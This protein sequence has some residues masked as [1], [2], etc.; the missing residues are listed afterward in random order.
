MTPL[1]GTLARRLLSESAESELSSDDSEEEESPRDFE[2]SLWNARALKIIS[3][4]MGCAQGT[5]RGPSRGD[6]RQFPRWPT[7]SY[8]HRVQALT[9]DHMNTLAS[10]SKGPPIPAAPPSA[11]DRKAELI[12]IQA[13]LAAQLEAVN[14]E[15]AEVQ[16]GYSSE[17]SAGDPDPAVADTDP[18]GLERANSGATE[19]GSPVRPDLV[20]PYEFKGGLQGIGDADTQKL[21]RVGMLAC[22]LHS[23]RSVRA[24]VRL[25]E[26][27][28]SESLE[29]FCTREKRNTRGEFFN[30][31]DFFFSFQHTTLHSIHMYVD[32][33]C[34]SP[35]T[36]QCPFVLFTCLIVVRFVFS[37]STGGGLSPSSALPHRHGGMPMT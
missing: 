29:I 9:R 7:E 22:Y 25:L 2:A 3:R 37:A 14:G 8:A 10:M 33:I 24:G 32:R 35:I 15:L 6:T 28:S 1:A 4:G 12:R 21:W 5:I 17:G 30:F 20:E 34:H 13:N 16:I 23:T 27:D 19:M 31:G 11:A 36:P 26:E 18:V